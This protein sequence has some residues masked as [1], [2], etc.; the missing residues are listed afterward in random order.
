MR[1]NDVSETLLFISVVVVVIII[2]GNQSFSI[3]QQ[4]TTLFYAG[5]APIYH[6]FISNKL[7]MDT[8]DTEYNSSPI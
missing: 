8:I 7:I 5:R 3:E 4:I 1:D 6:I 2:H